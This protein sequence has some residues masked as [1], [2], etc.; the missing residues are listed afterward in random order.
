MLK[1]ELVTALCSVVEHRSSESIRKRL[2]K[3]GWPTMKV[4]A[5]GETS[6]SVE[7]PLK[8]QGSD[9]LPQPLEGEEISQTLQDQ[10][11]HVREW[12]RSILEGVHEIM[13]SCGRSA[14]IHPARR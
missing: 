3:L 14:G 6:G 4:P 1:K 9:Q 12:R 7:L 8:E 11:L 10:H 2:Q 13:G 5:G